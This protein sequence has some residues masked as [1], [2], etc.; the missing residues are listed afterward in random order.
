MLQVVAAA[1]GQG[2][3]AV[4]VAVGVGVVAEG[5]IQ[6]LGKGCVA[7]VVDILHKGGD[8]AWLFGAEHGGHGRA[9]HL[10]QQGNKDKKQQNARHN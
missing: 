6:F 5:R 1:V 10:P 9:R 2:G 7:V 8:I 3:V 4:G